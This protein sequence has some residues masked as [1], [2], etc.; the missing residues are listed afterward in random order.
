MEVY[1]RVLCQVPPHSDAAPANIKEGYW[2]S[3][4]P[5]FP[6]TE[7]LRD[8]PFGVEETEKATFHALTFVDLL[9]QDGGLLVLHPGTQFFRRDE[10]GVVGNLVMRE[11]EFA[12]YAR[13]WLAHLCGVPLPP[14]AAW[15]RDNSQRATT[16]RARVQPACVLRGSPGPARRLAPAEEFSRGGSRRRPTLRTPPQDR[17]QRRIA[18]RRSGRTA[19]RDGAHARLS[20]GCRDR[21]QFT[22]QQSGRRGAQTQ[23]PPDHCGTVE[24]PH[25]RTQVRVKDVVGE[26]PDR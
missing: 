12:F 1:V 17:R 20:G 3:L 10:Q 9:G 2:L 22:R 7:V 8:F 19:P 15:G 23:H 13:V 6:V 24:D 16:S 14:D 18:R 5:A 26:T 25:I 11:W 4:R 21:D